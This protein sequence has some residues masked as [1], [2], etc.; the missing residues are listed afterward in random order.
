MRHKAFKVGE[1]LNRDECQGRLASLTYN[2]S[3]N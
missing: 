1:D 3:D 2:L